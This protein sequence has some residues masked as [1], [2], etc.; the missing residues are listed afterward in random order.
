MCHL[1]LRDVLPPNFFALSIHVSAS[2]SILLLHP[3]GKFPWNLWI[4]VHNW[5]LILPSPSVTEK[6][7][8]VGTLSV[9]T[10]L[11]KFRGLLVNK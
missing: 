9:P 5:G 6:S 8:S 3:E 10:D 2:V 7:K 4:Y 1:Q 11:V